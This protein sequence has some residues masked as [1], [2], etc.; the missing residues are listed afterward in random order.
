MHFNL[1]D[2]IAVLLA[3]VIRAYPRPARKSQDRPVTPEVAGSSPVAPVENTLQIGIFCCQ[4]WRD[5]PPAFRT[6]QAL[7]GYTSPRLGSVT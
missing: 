7:S 6:G 3:P 4:G 5:R 1:V 2:G